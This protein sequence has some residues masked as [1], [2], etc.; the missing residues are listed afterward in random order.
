MKSIKSR[1]KRLLHVKTPTGKAIRYVRRKLGV[2]VCADCRA[3]L[4]GVARSS[5]LIARTKKRPSRPFGGVYCSG[6]SRIRFKA[7]ARA[8]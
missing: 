7:A 1:H 4:P 3:A 6:C 2:P 8:Q 5:N